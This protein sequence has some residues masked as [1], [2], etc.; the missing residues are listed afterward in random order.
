MIVYGHAESN[1]AWLALLADSPVQIRR[2]SVRIGQRELSGDDLAY[3]I[4]P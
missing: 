2:G 3:Q 4:L 1:A